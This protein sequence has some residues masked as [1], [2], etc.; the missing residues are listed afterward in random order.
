MN[1]DR[2]PQAREAALLLHGLPDE[3]RRGV[4]AR[5]S[6]DER[7]RVMPLL[8]ELASLG[9]PRRPHRVVPG[10]ADGPQGP[11]DAVDRLSPEHVLDAVRSCSDVTL[12]LLLDAGPWS[13]QDTVLAGLPVERRIAVQ[14]LCGHEAPPPALVGSLCRSVLG[15]FA[16][17]AKTPVRTVPRWNGLR[18]WFPWTR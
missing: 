8:D 2:S 17:A 1:P 15:A 5:L 18:R 12:S 9:I 4:L 10:V 16:P 6:D 11:R 13:W 7:G 3:A 14:A